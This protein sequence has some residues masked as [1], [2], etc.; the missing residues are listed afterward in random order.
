MLALPADW[1]LFPAL[2]APK[3]PP[4]WNP[5]RSPPLFFFPKDCST[6][7]GL[8]NCSV[9]LSYKALLNEALLLN[10]TKAKPKDFPSTLVNN[11]TLMTLPKGLN[12]SSMSLW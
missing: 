5:P 10:L 6:V 7:I 3:F 4:F 2:L 8:P 12:K 9:P 1:N 11:L